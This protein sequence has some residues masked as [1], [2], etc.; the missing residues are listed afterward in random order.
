MEV[1]MKKYLRITI[2][3]KVQG[4]FFRQQT[5]KH[6]LENNITGYVQNCKDGTVLIECMGE[7]EDMR[8]FLRFCRKGSPAAHVTNVYVEES[9]QKNDFVTFNIY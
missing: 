9:D 1:C 3:G 2:E 4:V 5:K 7:E 6:A 8:S